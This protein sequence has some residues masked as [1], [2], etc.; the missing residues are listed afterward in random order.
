[1]PLLRFTRFP[2]KVLNHTKKQTT[3]RRRKNPIKKEDLLYIYTYI[4]AGTARVT[5]ITPLTYGTCTDK[6]AQKDGF[7]N[8]EEY[9]KGLKELHPK[10][11][12]ILE[13]DFDIIEYEPFWPP[14]EVIT[15][16]EKKEL[17]MYQK[18]SF[19]RTTEELRHK[20]LNLNR[21]HPCCPRCGKSMAFRYSDH[22]ILGRRSTAVYECTSKKCTIATL[23]L[24]SKWKIHER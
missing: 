20:Q 23:I 10:V 18:E 4:Y 7:K 12:D 5:K 8:K 17:L 9:L 15:L 14:K 1:M 13:D 11:A 6:V 24:Y 22:R 19:I 2:N 3:R 21:S 16:Q